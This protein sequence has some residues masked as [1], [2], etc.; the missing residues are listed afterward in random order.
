M[1]ILCVTAKSDTVSLPSWKRECNEYKEATRDV[2]S[3]LHP[4]AISQRLGEGDSAD[5]LLLGRAQH[6]LG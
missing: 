3:P 6:S 1:H 2:V 5:T 4:E